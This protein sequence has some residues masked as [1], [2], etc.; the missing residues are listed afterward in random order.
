VIVYRLM[1]E[2]LRDGPWRCEGYNEYKD[3]PS[4]IEMEDHW[5]YIGEEDT[6]NTP[7]DDGIDYFSLRDLWDSGYVCG[8]ADIDQ[9]SH[10]F[11]EF[12]EDWISYGFRLFEIEIPNRFVR[13]L[14]HQVLLSIADATSERIVPVDEYKTMLVEGMTCV[15]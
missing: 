2:R 1:H 11:G 10:W 5:R 14:R 7:D 12:W 9:V 15:T 13:E 4:W 6:H 3:E 8:C